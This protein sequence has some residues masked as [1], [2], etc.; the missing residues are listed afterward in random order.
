MPG[1]EVWVLRLAELWRVLLDFE[2]V[3]VRDEASGDSQTDMRLT[4]EPS[5][6]RVLEEA[7]LRVLC[8]DRRKKQ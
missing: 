2:I 7:S 5:Q 6:K 1:P 8:L 4:F 3:D